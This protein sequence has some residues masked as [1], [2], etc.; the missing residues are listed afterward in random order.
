MRFRLILALGLLSG[1]LAA[2]TLNAPIIN[3]PSGTY[4]NMAWTTLSSN[5]TFAGG[6]YAKVCLTKDGTTPTATV[7]GTCDN[8]GSIYDGVQYGYAAA[9]FDDVGTFTL[10]AIST[11]AGYTNSSVASATYTITSSPALATLT[12]TKPVKVTASSA[13]VNYFMPYVVTAPNGRVL[14]FFGAGAGAP[15]HG[16]AGWLEMMYSDDDGAT[17]DDYA[18]S[19]VTK[20]YSTSIG[21]GYTSATCAI[22]APVSGTTATCTVGAPV[23]GAIPSIT[24]DSGGGGYTVTGIPYYTHPIVVNASGGGCSVLP[25]AEAW[26]NDT[27]T[28]AIAGVRMKTYGAGCTSAPS[29]SITQVN[30]TGTATCHFGDP[31]NGAVLPPTLTGRGTGYAS[32]PSVTISG[33]GTGATVSA[34]LNDC[35]PG[36]PARCFWHDSAYGQ[37]ELMGGGVSYSGTVVVTAFDSQLG[38]SSSR[39][40]RVWRSTDD[41]ATWGQSFNVALAATQTHSPANMLSIPPSSAG[42]TGACAAGCLIQWTTEGA[43][44]NA[45]F[46]MKSFDDGV[47]WSGLTAVG[48]VFPQNDEE[49]AIA[50]AGGMKLIAYTRTGRSASNNLGWPEPLFVHTSSDLGAT[51]SHYLSNI[52][53]GPCTVNPDSYFWS[54]QYTKPSGFVNPKDA[55][56]FT[57]ILGERF[58]CP[59]GSDTRWRTTTFNMADTH[60]GHGQNTPM[61]QMLNLAPGV[62][63]GSGHTSYSGAWPT[64]SG[65]VLMAFERSVSTTAEDIYVTTLSYPSTPETLTITSSSPLPTGTATLVYSQNLT[66]TGGVPSYSWAITSGSLAACGL[67]L[68][69]AGTVS[70]SSP[71]AATCNFTAEVTDSASA[72]ASKAFNLTVNST[73]SMQFSGG[74]SFTGGVTMR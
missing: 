43:S 46:T 45:N 63:Y 48:S 21:S 31:V 23:N 58:G 7:A 44:A 49:T 62:V 17:W 16:H 20:L 73:N 74:V 72:T 59:V 5:N 10:K 8:N 50:W 68:S 55:S 70:G 27:S 51:W 52:P 53:T 56:Q 12:N 4:T 11:L 60:T 65:K 38:W 61:P 35:E 36:D 24:L 9:E 34:T 29:C 22:A 28:H 1:S 18:P 2:Q 3:L 57:M 37:T 25:T 19:T 40:P 67:T 26:V 6:I 64:A 15:D 33:D 42:V 71:T 13:G 69:S 54:D 30:N 41:G 39:G 14:M 32:V 47:T 66:A